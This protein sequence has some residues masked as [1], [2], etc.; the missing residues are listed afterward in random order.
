MCG[1]KDLFVD[2]KYFYTIGR[3]HQLWDEDGEYQDI[4]SIKRTTS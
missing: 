1:F 3:D 4:V 2:V